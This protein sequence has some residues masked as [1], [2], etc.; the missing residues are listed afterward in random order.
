[1]GRGCNMPYGKLLD[2]ATGGGGGGGGGTPPAG[3]ITGAVP[4]LRPQGKIESLRAAIMQAEISA[5]RLDDP[6]EKAVLGIKIASMREE[7]ARLIASAEAKK[8]KSDE[9]RT[10]SS[11]GGGG[12][13]GGGNRD[14]YQDSGAR[15]RAFVGKSRGGG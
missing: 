12:G 10:A 5:A 14:G 13:G 4:G 8:A 9:G 6:K 15:W 3:G 2:I 11:S 7:L 1:M